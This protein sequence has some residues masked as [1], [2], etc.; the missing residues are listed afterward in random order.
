MPWDSVRVRVGN[1]CMNMGWLGWCL[2]GRCMGGYSCRLASRSQLLQTHFN[3]SVVAI[4]H[5]DQQVGGVGP[6]KRG[7]FRRIRLAHELLR[8]AAAGRGLFHPK[9]PSAP[10]KSLEETSHEDLLLE[11]L[12]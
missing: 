10:A 12:T 1:G 6:A 11:I 5:Y 8:R 2:R 9:L 7:K 4:D 3:A